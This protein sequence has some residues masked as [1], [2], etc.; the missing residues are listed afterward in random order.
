MLLEC[1]CSAKREEREKD[2]GREREREKKMEFPSAS[3]LP[4]C[5][6]TTVAEPGL[7]YGIENA[8]QVSRGGTWMH[9]P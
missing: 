6:Q 8:I 9:S 1:I 5:P 2:G 4:K 7:T 3:I